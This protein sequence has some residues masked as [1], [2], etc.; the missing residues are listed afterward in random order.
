MSIGFMTLDRRGA[1]T[2]GLASSRFRAET[3]ADHAKAAQTLMASGQH[4]AAAARLAQAIQLEPGSGQHHWHLAHCQWA[5]GDG[6]SAGRSLEV[7]VKVDPQLAVAHASLAEWYLIHGMIEPALSASA[8]AFALSP[9]NRGVL[10]ARA[11]VLEASGEL[12]AAWDVVQQAIA[13]QQAVPPIVLLYAR[14]ARRRGHQGQALAL[15]QSMIAAGG[16]SV[17][18]ESALHMAAAD[19]LDGLGRYDEAF[20]HAIRGNKIRMPHWNPSE[21]SQSVDRRIEYFTADRIRSLPRSTNRSPKPVFIVGML[22]SGTSLVEQILASHPAIHGAG[23][24]DLMYWTWTGTLDMLDATESE[25]PACLDR[26]SVEQADGMSNIYLG[27]LSALNPSAERIIDKMPLNFLHLG[28]IATLLPGARIIHCRRDPLDICLSCYMTQF[29][30]G[31]AFKYDLAHLGKFYKDY[32]RLMTHW[33][34]V[35]DIPILDVAYEDVIAD[36]P[37]QTRKMLDFLGMPWDDRC[38]RF[39]E[40]KRSVATASVQQV[41]H[42]IYTSSKQRWRNYE[43]YLGPLKAAMA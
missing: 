21:H 10:A 19:L 8:R 43:R 2:L 22:R 25:Y 40:T 1:G 12:D 20:G 7:A 5:V 29:S 27:P 39:H 16:L 14:M 26:L 31:N 34:S 15:V 6:D 3:A 33:K 35:L 17:L 4:A 42:P 28:L 23:E 30:H 24:L 9:H 11:V 41:R 18:D 13:C 38:T 37:G 32:E 36:A